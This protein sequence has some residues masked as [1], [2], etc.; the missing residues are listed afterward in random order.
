[1][2]LFLNTLDSFKELREMES[3]FDRLLPS[4]SSE[5]SLSDFSPAVNTREGDYAYHI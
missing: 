1:M 2:S 4:I 3:R 5:L